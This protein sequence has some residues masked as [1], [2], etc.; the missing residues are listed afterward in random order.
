MRKKTLAAV[1]IAVAAIFAMPVA[2][3]AAGY[4]PVTAV[5]SDTTPAPGQSVTVSFPDGTFANNESVGI[6]V[7]G[8]SSATV[9]VVK[10][11]TVS[12]TKPASATGSLS[13]V[14]TLPA[15]A[16]GTYTVTATGLSSGIVGT[17]VLTVTPAAAGGLAATG[18]NFPFLMVWTA[19]GALLLGIA[20]LIV[21]TVVRRQRAAATR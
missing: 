7:T 15:D 3:N 18:A 21:L 17:A 5:V 4:T 11:A 6:A 16:T 9:A 8:N 2:A 14:V 10:A 19:G 13:F 20:L 1:I 12:T